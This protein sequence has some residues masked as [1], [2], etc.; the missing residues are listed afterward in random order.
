MVHSE[1]SEMK[2]SELK[3]NSYLAYDGY[4]DEGFLSRI[5]HKGS[6]SDSDRSAI[7]SLL[8]DH[9][10]F[11]TVAFVMADLGPEEIYC[12]F[13]TFPFETDL[14]QEITTF[15]QNLGVS[16][17]VGL[18]RGHTYNV[19]VFEMPS[20]LPN[21]RVMVICFKQPSFTREQDDYIQ[22]GIFIPKAVLEYIPSFS[23]FEDIILKIVKLQ[24]GDSEFSDT[25]FSGTKQRILLFLSEIV[26]K[27]SVQS[28][29][30]E[31]V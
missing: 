2:L 26:R 12:D 7:L 19:G 23:S 25:R 13:S 16:F 10:N 18:A 14:D 1:S 11:P 9:S 15:L 27:Q 20:T 24:F 31:I 30:W 28:S 4:F 5:H 22:I 6:K 17:M 29:N 8:Y 21:Y 3:A